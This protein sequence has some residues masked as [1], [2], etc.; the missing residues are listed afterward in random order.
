[1]SWKKSRFATSLISLFSDTTPDL[2]DEGRIEVVRAVMLDALKG[3][4]ETEQVDIIT[5]R[6]HWAPHAQALWYLRIDVM[7]LLSE[8]H[9]EQAAR[10][11]LRGITE[12]FHGLISGNHMPRASRFNQHG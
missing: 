5:R 12:K 7:T 1:M 8:H 4:A 10:Q 9:G 6:L 2:P 11:T 3:L